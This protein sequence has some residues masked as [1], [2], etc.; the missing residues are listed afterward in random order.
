MIASQPIAKCVILARG[1]GTRMRREDERARLEPAQSFVAESGVKA[2]IPVEHDRP[3]LDYVLSALADAGFV[4]ICLVIGP[5]HQAIRDYY[6]RILR[7]KRIN[8]SFAV[9]QEPLGTANAVLASEEFARAGEFLVINSDNFY[10]AEV[11][12]NIQELGCPGTVLFEARHLIQVSKIPEERIR[13][14]AYCLVDG[15][16]FLADIVEKPENPSELGENGK[17]ISMNCRRFDSAIFPACRDVERSA[18]G[19]YELPQAV[20]L[21]IRCGSRF[22]VAISQAAVLDLSR[23]SDIATVADQL[24]NVEVAL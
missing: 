9:Q 22:K 10:P 21:A 24:K 13:A 12:R 3:F 16:R 6:G 15:N 8:V 11:L 23:R 5:E 7:P 2:M 1:L 19:E 20:R 4:S 17:L 14:F 18:R